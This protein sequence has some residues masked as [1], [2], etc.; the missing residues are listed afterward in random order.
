MSLIKINNENGISEITIDRPEALNAMNQEVVAEFSSV[1][2]A[3]LSDKETGIIIITGAGDKA[4]IAGAD[5]K[6]MQKM[7]AEEALIY[8]KAG[9]KL[10]ML[11]ESSP[12]PVIA[13]VNGFALG[14]G[15]EIAMACHI[16]IASENAS[17]GQPEVK[18][19]LLPGWGG[20]Q[21]LP[22]IIGVGRA[23]E[24]ITTGKIINAEEALRIGLA[25]V[26][27]PQ[28]ELLSS[29]R[30]MAS[31]ILRNGPRAIAS[32]LHCIKEGLSVPIKEGMEIE[33]QE[34]SKLFHHDE[35]MEGLTAFIEKRPADFRD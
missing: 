31:T 26:I 15:C 12:K 10:T 4:F 5:I 19:G 21:R 20:T 14:G 28:D 29:A 11:I 3:A 25:N 9:Q 22:K 17:F 8:G 6:A 34:F 2:Q 23:N 1:L 16:R 27:Y 32:L 30:K 13:A 18:L 24:L 35:R 7:T 33:V